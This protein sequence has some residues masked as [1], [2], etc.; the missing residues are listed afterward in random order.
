MKLM[1][2]VAALLAG[3]T[4]A[5]AYLFGASLGAADEQEEY[6]ST[7]KIVSSLT[8]DLAAFPGREA[9]VMKAEFPPGWVGGRHYHTGDVFVYVLEGSFVVDVD[10]VGPG[11]EGVRSAR[12]DRGHA[13]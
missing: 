3:A 5:S 13:D 8:D 1:P 9:T 6:V 10:G 12:G 4:L 11:G 7:A 2:R